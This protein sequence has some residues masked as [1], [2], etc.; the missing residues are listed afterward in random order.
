M[1]F[2]GHLENM[3]IR[4]LRRHFSACQ[5]WFLVQHTKLPQIKVSNLFLH[6]MPVLVNFSDVFPYHRTAYS[7]ASSWLPGDTEEVNTV[8]PTKDEFKIQ[9]VLKWHPNYLFQ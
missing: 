9:S 4:S 6:K 2:G 3:Q 8:Q 7:F 1:D 5:H